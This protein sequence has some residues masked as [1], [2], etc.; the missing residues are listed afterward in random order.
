MAVMLRAT[1]DFFFVAYVLAFALYSRPLKDLWNLKSLL[2]SSV[3]L[4]NFMQYIDAANMIEQLQKLIWPALLCVFGDFC[5]TYL[6][7]KN[8]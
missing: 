5:L 3:L 6:Y 4:E 7:E 2:G 1:L 8:R